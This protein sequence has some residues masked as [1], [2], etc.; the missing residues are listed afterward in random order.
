MTLPWQR[1]QLQELLFK[2]ILHA[3]QHVYTIGGRTPLELATL[4]IDAE[5]YLKRED[6][7]PIHSYKWRGAF[8]R[9]VHLTDAEKE[10]GV[11]CASAGNHAQGVALAAAHLGL[12]AKIIMPQPTPRMKRVA[13]ERHGGNH[14][15]AIFHGDTFAEA[16]ALAR[17]LQAAE[18]LTYIHAYDDYLTMGGQ[19]TIADE[20]VMSGLDSLD[21]AF[22]QIGGG[23][24]AASMACW[25]KT[26]FPA[27]RVIGVEGD[28]QAS[29]AL[30]V[31]S[32]APTDLPYVD[33]FAD[34]TAVS[35]AGD[36]THPLCAELI[37]EFITVTN[38]ELCAAIQLLWESQRVI[39]EPA[40][41]MGVAGLMKKAGEVRGKRA[42]CVI[43]GSNMDFGQLA[44]IARHA[45]IG[46]QRRRY[47]R[48]EIDE[49]PGTFLNLIRTG[50]EEIDIVEFQYGKCDMLKAWPVIGFEASEIEIDLLH[51]RL[52][53]E[54]IPYADVTSQTDVEFRLIHYDSTL[55]NCPFFM[56]HEFP[57]RAGA[58]R[59]F[60]SLFSDSAS[61]IYFNYVYTGER[62]GRALMGFEFDSGEDRAGFIATLSQSG[63]DYRELDPAVLERIL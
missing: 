22:L 10:R 26:F 3:R 20:V 33:V 30:A 11:I 31:K 42:L 23:G 51:Q 61:L 16:S 59:D 50:F 13:V 54:R 25:L 62:V 4:P 53:D 57:E 29:M 38:E 52:A 49:R 1:S 32:G 56:T 19:G 2:E 47:Y 17:S 41:A 55:F 5:V 18:D 24:M 21:Y 45:G 12:H 40:G 7:S 35:R 8:N 43:C 60:L 37:D 44:W 58:L 63:R 46:S 15:E 27:I 34:G 28:G 39:P 6:V 14:V 48:F 9:M 36:L